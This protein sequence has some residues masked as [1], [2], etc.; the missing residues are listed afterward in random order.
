MW[1]Q[2][3]K[4]LTKNAQHVCNTATKRFESCDVVCFTTDVRIRLQDFFVVGGKTR[5]IVIQ[6]VLQQ[7]RFFVARFTVPLD[8]LIFFFSFLLPLSFSITHFYVFVWVNYT[9]T[10]LTRAALLALS[11]SIYQ[12][13]ALNLRPGPHES[14]HFWNRILCYPNSCGQDMKTVQSH[15]SASSVTISI[16]FTQGPKP[17][18]LRRAV[19]KT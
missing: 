11:K 3:V 4:R 10:I 14:R 5:N 16:T 19:S 8:L 9:T 12:E 2:Q 15:S 7:Y 6:L 1:S 13:I 18:A 17:H